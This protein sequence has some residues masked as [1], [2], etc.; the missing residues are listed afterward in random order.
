MTVDT[1]TCENSS[2]DVHAFELVYL[3]MVAKAV[4]VVVLI[5]LRKGR[6]DLSVTSAVDAEAS[7]P[8]PPYSKPNGKG[9]G[10][11]RENQI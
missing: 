6:H 8:P 4:E 11:A 3:R 2:K 9:E 10:L 7:E 5:V 1:D